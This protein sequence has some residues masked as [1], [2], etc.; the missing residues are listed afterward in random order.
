MGR[1]RVTIAGIM[2]FV[3]AV[4]FGFAALH[5]RAE[6][7]ITA[8]DVFSFL[9]LLTA[10]PGAIWNRGHG[11]A[12]W[13]GVALFGWAVKF[14]S[15]SP[16]RHVGPHVNYM[17]LGEYIFGQLDRTKKFADAATKHK[18]ENIYYNNITYF[19]QTSSGLAVLLFALIGGLIARWFAIRYETRTGAECEGTAR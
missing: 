4:G 12:F 16:L 14:T 2:A 19:A 9:L 15:L 7:W 6:P 5:A 11:R 18:Y 3:A 10:I 17:G 8:I 13:F 1:S